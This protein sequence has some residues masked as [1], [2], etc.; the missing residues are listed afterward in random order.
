M[1]WSLC[2]SLP[3]A[4]DASENLITSK[5]KLHTK[6]CK[7]YSKTSKLLG[8]GGGV[9]EMSVSV[10]NRHIPDLRCSYVPEGLAQ[11]EFCASQN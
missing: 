6:K 11:V 7:T 1:S 9:R 2:R 5:E 4:R 8:G 3:L 10:Y